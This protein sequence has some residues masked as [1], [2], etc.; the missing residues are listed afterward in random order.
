MFGTFV[1]KEG[2]KELKQYGATFT[3]N[4]KC[5]VYHVFKEI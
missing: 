1:A 3:F 4:G 2:R 5:L